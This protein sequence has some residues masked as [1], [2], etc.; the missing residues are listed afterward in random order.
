M[1]FFKFLLFGIFQLLAL[2][3]EAIRTEDLI[4]FALL[5][6]HVDLTVTGSTI[7]R[8]FWPSEIDT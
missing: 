4:L 5:H 8:C 7:M 3:T 6:F 1:E 2:R